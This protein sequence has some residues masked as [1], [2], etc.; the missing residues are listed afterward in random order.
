MVFGSFWNSVEKNNNTECFGD[1]VVRTRGFK[2]V[3]ALIIRS[4]EIPEIR[5]S[6]NMT[7][8]KLSQVSILYTIYYDYLTGPHWRE[9]V[10]AYFLPS[11]SNAYSRAL[12]LINRD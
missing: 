8:F 11:N 12:A 9:G 2:K 4:M 10:T 3:L 6:F 7:S 1:L 5:R